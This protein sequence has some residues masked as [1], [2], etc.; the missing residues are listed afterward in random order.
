MVF[1]EQVAK[2]FDE[3]RLRLLGDITIPLIS[4]ALDGILIVMLGQEWDKL[5]PEYVGMWCGRRGGRPC[6]P[7]D[8]GVVTFPLFLVSFILH[9]AVF[10]G[11][12]LE[13]PRKRISRWPIKFLGYNFLTV[14]IVIY[15]YFSNQIAF[16][17]GVP[18]LTARMFLYSLYCLGRAL[19]WGCKK[20]NDWEESK[21]NA[22]VNLEYVEQPVDQPNTSIDIEEERI[23]AKFNEDM[24]REYEKTL[25]VLR[26]L[27]LI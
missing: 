27:L 8:C 13:L 18:I 26:Q 7:V 14:G 20:W 10:L 22:R 11:M 25:D 15:G 23:M 6:F 16:E 5:V 12:F 17:N 2:A 9:G 24:K 4:L 21:K 3:S 19:L 1:S